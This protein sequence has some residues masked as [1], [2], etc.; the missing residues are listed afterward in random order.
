MRADMSKLGQFRASL[1]QAKGWVH[2][3][4]KMTRQFRRIFSSK[5]AAEGMHVALRTVALNN[6]FS[7]A[8]Q[9]WPANLCQAVSF[10]ESRK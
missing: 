10:V 2:G 4:S 1:D 6:G 3:N 8:Q 7:S 9:C 5:D